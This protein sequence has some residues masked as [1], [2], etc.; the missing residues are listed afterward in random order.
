MVDYST[1]RI[2]RPLINEVSKALKSIDAYGS[3][4]IYVQNC[5]VTQIT[6]RNIRKTDGFG[7]KSKSKK[8]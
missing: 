6:V 1:K 3:V 4:E 2:S 8:D 5:T 7:S